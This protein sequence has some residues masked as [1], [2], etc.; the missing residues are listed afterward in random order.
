ME[1]QTHR[2]IKTLYRNL[3]PA[4]SYRFVLNAAIVIQRGRFI[5]V[6]ILKTKVCRV[7][8]LD[9]SLEGGMNEVIRE[10]KSISAW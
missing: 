9:L 5:P 8:T 7:S 10:K 1:D 4:D 3:Y 6:C 2:A